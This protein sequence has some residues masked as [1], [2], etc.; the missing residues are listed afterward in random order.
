MAEMDLQKKLNDLIAKHGDLVANASAV[1]GQESFDTE[2]FNSVKTE[3]ANV[4]AEINAVRETLAM[5]GD[6]DGN[7]FLQDLANQ[8]QT[9]KEDNVMTSKVDKIRSTNEYARAFAM[10]ARIKT[11]IIQMDPA[12]VENQLAPLFDALRCMPQVNNAMTQSGGNP[13]GSDGGFLVPI[14]IENRIIEL[15][16]SMI[17]FAQFANTENVTTATGWRVMEV[18]KASQ[19]LQVVGELQPTPASEQPKFRQVPYAI[20][21][22]RGN[23]LLSQELVDDEVANLFAYLA[24]WMAHKAVLTENAGL[25]GLWPAPAITFDANNPIGTLKQMANVE[26]DPAIK[27]SSRWYVNQNSFNYLDELEDANGRPL[28]QPDPT[29]STGRML[30]GIPVSVAPNAYLPDKSNGV[31][32]VYLGDMAEFETVFRR[33][34]FELEFSRFVQ[35]AWD[36]YAVEGRMIKRDDYVKFDDAAMIGTQITY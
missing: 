7:P 16:R 35:G 24:R 14:D 26:I 6:V 34:G 4:S 11:P 19:V 25:I 20:K 21:T 29:Q 5:K 28:L 17:D 9:Q 27:I 33:K 8:L 31:A 10:A 2:K 13:V 30:L 23:I 22:R 15:R 32:P 18:N 3:V 1:V 36:N 12:L